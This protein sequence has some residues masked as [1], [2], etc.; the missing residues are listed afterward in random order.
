MSDSVPPPA[1]LHTPDNPSLNEVV[2]LVIKHRVTAGREVDYESWLRRIVTIAGQQPGHLGVDVI[3]SKDAGLQMFTSVLRFQSTLVMQ[4]WLDS[5]ER[6]Q[7]VAEAAPMLADGDQTQVN[8]HNEFWFTPPSEDRSP[9][10]RWKQAC[11]SYMVILPLT[12]LIPQVW[13][14]VF[15]QVSWLSG[16][17][18]STAL[19]TVTIVLLVV[20]VLMPA[21][22]RLL[23]PWLN[24]SAEHSQ[25]K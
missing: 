22:T 20:Y 21:A 3:R 24:A 25:G 15:A 11:V 19:V 8:P 18:I 9:P 13:R 14:P 16:Y 4:Q 6:R 1:T 17:F 5:D 23:A 12:L 7:L 2:T 10:P